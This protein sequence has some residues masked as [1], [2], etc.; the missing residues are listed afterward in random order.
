MDN[1]ILNLFIDG[2]ASSLLENIVAIHLYKNKRDSLYYLKGNKTD[3]D[4]YIS[5]ENVAIQVAYSIKEI[6]SF[7]REVSSLI[8]F[9]KKEKEKTKLIIVTYDEEDTINKDGYTINVL[10]LK[11]FLLSE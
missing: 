1:G 7:D 8:E 9:A 5:N 6:E 10:P 11:K 2:K 4:F 3:I